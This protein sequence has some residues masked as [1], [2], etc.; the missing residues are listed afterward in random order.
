MDRLRSRGTP[1]LYRADA[2]RHEY[3]QAHK[4]LEGYHDGFADGNLHAHMP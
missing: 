3:C 1:F 2:H 4:H